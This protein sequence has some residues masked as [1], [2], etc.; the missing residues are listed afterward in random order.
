[1]FIITRRT[2]FPGSV[3]VGFGCLSQPGHGKTNQARPLWTR[4]NAVHGWRMATVACCHVVFAL[5][6]NFL[7]PLEME[8]Y[9]NLS[10]GFWL[11][12]L[13]RLTNLPYSTTDP[14]VWLGLLE[15][16]PTSLCGFT[17]EI[18]FF[19]FFFTPVDPQVLMASAVCTHNKS[20]VFTLLNLSLKV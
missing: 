7:S 14:Q 18:F 15:R 1:M 20:T 8:T 9:L 11:W 3:S 12:F 16:T 4:R 17:A 5:K 10:S 6:E 13:I 2:N 19:S